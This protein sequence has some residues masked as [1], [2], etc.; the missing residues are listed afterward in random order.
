MRNWVKPRI[1]TKRVQW[2]WVFAL[3]RWVSM[4]RGTPIQSVPA[5]DILLFPVA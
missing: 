2:R 3:L 1:E 4:R 5:L